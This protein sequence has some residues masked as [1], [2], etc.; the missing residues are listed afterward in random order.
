MSSSVALI[1]IVAYVSLLYELVFLKVPSV[2]SSL[3]I[4]R[5]NRALVGAYSPRY[6]RVFE[7]GTLRKTLFLSVPLLIIFYVFSFPVGVAVIA[8]NFVNDYL[9]LPSEYT[10]VATIVLVLLGRCITVASV[11][12]IRKDNAQTGNSF[13]LHTAGPFCWS[14]NPGLV[15]MYVFALGMWLSMPSASMLIGIIVY[16]AHMHFRVRMEED[17]LVNKFGA[18]YLSYLAKSPRYLL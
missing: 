3:Q 9:Y 1:I 15:G 5:K 16:V 12:A 13:F 8:P 7:F 10:D 11:L 18:E 4:W 14:R 17:F 6:R 2:A